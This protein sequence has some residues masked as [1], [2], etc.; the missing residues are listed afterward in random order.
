M[1]AYK[2]VLPEARD[3]EEMTDLEYP[4]TSA[5]G[6]VTAIVK[7]LG[8]GGESVGYVINVTNHES[9]G[10]DVSLAV[11]VLADGSV[12]AIE[13]LEINDTPGLGMKA[14]DEAFKKGFEGVSIDGSSADA[15][16][17][18]SGVDGI[19][20]ATITTNAVKKAVFAALSSVEN[21]QD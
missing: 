3:F 9:Y 5:D 8:D 21:I 6:D 1:N 10:G 20:G 2:A 16:S 4:L 19:S 15:L 7:G 17:A 13:V 11:G 14:K 18:M 12:G